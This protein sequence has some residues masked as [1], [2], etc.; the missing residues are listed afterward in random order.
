MKVFKTN[1]VPEK[2]FKK[3]ETGWHGS[4]PTADTHIRMIHGSARNKLLRTRRLLLTR[5][6]HPAQFPT[7]RTRATRYKTHL[8]KEGFTG[9]RST[10]FALALTLLVTA[11]GCSV[12]LDLLPDALVSTGTPFVISGTAA[13]V[14]SD[15][16]C[17]IWIG[18]NGVTYHLF[19]TSRVDNETF[20]R[21]ISPGVTSR[22]LI[23]LRTDLVVT[24]Q[25]GTIAEVQNV[26]EI[27]E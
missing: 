16:A 9:Y 22:L 23:A 21:V 8:L 14:D 6:F 26:L 19:Q 7:G 5:V 13:V 20:D 24:C 12:S 1:M 15:G 27:V 10:T 17:L 3:T 18:E 11:S 25:I 4:T 2:L